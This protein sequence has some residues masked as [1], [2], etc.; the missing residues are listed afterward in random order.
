[1][2]VPPAADR[3]RF[4][5]FQPALSLLSRVVSRNHDG[6]VTIDAGLKALYRDGAVPLV[7]SHPGANYDWFGDEHGKLTLTPGT[8]KPALG[9]LVELSVSHCDPTINLF[10]R[11]HV[12]QAGVVVDC[13]DIDLRGKAQ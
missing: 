11:F 12:V 13:W 1:M 6:F 4:A 3:G 9:E 2:S 5:A 7:L 10:D 8:A